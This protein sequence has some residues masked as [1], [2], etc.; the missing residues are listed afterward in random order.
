MPTQRAHSDTSSGDSAQIFV[1]ES[2]AAVLGVRE[3]L[4]RLAPDSDI[5]KEWAAELRWYGPGD[6]AAWNEEMQRLVEAET[7]AA[8][9][10]SAHEQLRGALGALPGIERPLRKLRAGEALGEVELFGLKQFLYYGG[11]AIEAALDL[12]DGWGVPQSWSEQIAAL[13]ETIHPQRRPTPRFH[14]A[15]ELSDE[16]EALRLDLRAAKRRRRKR[17][18]ALEEA[19]VASYGGSFDFHGNYHLSP[20]TGSDDELADDARLEHTGQG[21]E[22]SD[23]ELAGLSDDIER[24]EAEVE[25]VERDLR[26]RLSEVLVDQ[27]DWLEEVAEILA[28]LDVRLAKVRLKDDLEGSWPDWTDAGGITIEQG[29]EPLTALR[30][31]ERD[32]EIQPVDASVGDTPVVITGPNMGGK[33]VLLRLVG[34]CQWCAQHAMGV[35]AAGCDFSAVQRIVYVGSEEPRAKSASLG[36]SSFGREVRRLVDLWDAAE[37]PG[38]WL[39]DELGRGTHPDE[40]ASIA[41]E[42]VGK[43]SARGDR[44]AAATHFPAVASMEGVERLRIAGLVHPKKLEELLE[45][46]GADVHTALRRCMDYRTVAVDDPGDHAV[47]RDA[48]VVARAL[49]LKLE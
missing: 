37:P 5:G 41:S 38:L 11:E 2:T 44:V 7:W 49:G 4:G 8:N 17:R 18:D 40:G 29:R 20:D 48:R 6:R 19:L 24:R 15:D 39:L 26:A 13:M 35:P 31:A 14:L 12:V 10:P 1:D 43:L 16:L 32:E 27:I 45:E 21:W 46:D 22:L 42:L 34:I 9:E 3:L 28:L 36:L 23:E 47:P 33:S 30:L 25:A